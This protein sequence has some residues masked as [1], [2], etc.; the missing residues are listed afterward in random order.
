MTILITG[1]TGKTGLKLARL[2]HEAKHSILLASRSGKVPAPFHG[3]AFDWFNPS[4]YENPFN[5]VT[6]DNAIDSVYLVGPSVQIDYLGN[7]R[8]FIDLAKAKGVKRFV[9]MSASSYVSGSPAMGKVHEY[10][11][12][13]GVDYCILRPT[14]FQGVYLP[15]TPG[16]SSSRH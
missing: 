7:M 15:T 6:P 4:T 5:A 16:Q 12:G 13:L 9:M 10:L 8:A 11:E 3:V 14:W 2:L 1:G